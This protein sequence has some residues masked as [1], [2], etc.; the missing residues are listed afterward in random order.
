MTTP[1]AWQS[2]FTEG[3]LIDYRHFDSKNIIPLYEFGF[4]L[5]YTTFGLADFSVTTLVKNLAST[6][7]ISRRIA[8]GGNPDLFTPIIQA[9]V[10]VSNTGSLAGATVAQ[11]YISM[12]DSAPSGTPVKVLRGFE[13]VYLEP[14]ET[15][16]VDFELMRR[17]VSY[18]DVLEQTWKIPKGDFKFAV[19][20]SSRDLKATRVEALL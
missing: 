3:L 19:G 1:G 4:G 20:F 9:S 14:G 18:W 12:P 8:P 10:A 7:D 15:K 17:D 5:S 11:L 16:A 2:D 13:K 6:P